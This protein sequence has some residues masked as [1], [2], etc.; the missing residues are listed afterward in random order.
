MNYEELLK[1][2]EEHVTLF[3]FE[4]NDPKRVF[5]QPANTSEI[6]EAVNKM[7]GHYK[8]DE[9]DRF[10]VYSSAWFHGMGYHL[11]G[12]EES[13]AKTAAA[14]SSFLAQ[15]VL[16]SADI[17][18]VKNCILST[19]MPQDPVDLAQKILCDAV[20]FYVGTNQFLEK[21]KLLRKE[22]ENVSGKKISGAEWRLQTIAFLEAHHFHTD[23]CQQLLQEVKM[24]HVDALKLKME[25]K[26]SVERGDALPAPPDQKDKKKKT[27]D[28]KKSRRPKGIETMF[29]ISSTNHQRMSALA[30]NK[31]NILI[32]VNSI[33]ISLIISLM[34]PRL[35]TASRLIIPTIILLAV[36]IA[37]IVYS[38]I[39][40]RPRKQK[41]VFTAEQIKNKSVN[42][43]FFGSFY[44]MGFKD[45]QN[46]IHL[47]MND[48][49][50]L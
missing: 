18:A 1:R 15:Q 42:L 34:I 10:I 44:R 40:T 19:R 14:A 27:K 9:R 25:D 7:N 28:K 36:S 33:I 13:L 11:P 45:Y 12:Q 46:G 31:A 23:Y 24:Q 21:N 20:Y 16:P 50:F 2:I 17:D 49:D 6:I 30:D 32:S 48:T 37:T 3:Y 39:A 43:L 8:L 5:H 22:R 38:I 4:K 29:R 35:E 47:V 41:G 26:P